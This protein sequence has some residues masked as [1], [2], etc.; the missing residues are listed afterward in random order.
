MSFVAVRE[1]ITARFKANVTGLPII[2]ANQ[3]PPPIAARWVQ[4]Q[5]EFLTTQQAGTGGPGARRWR[6]TGRVALN[7][8]ER[9][10]SGDGSMLTLM[11]TITGAFRGVTL[12][13]ANGLSFGAPTFLG[14]SVRDE[15]GS[16]WR[17]PAEIPFRADVV[18]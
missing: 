8:F 14:V 2:Q 11:D 7:L 18:G 9:A 12:D 4:M 15:A 3:S 6:I 10:D 13:V 16:H 1:A 17:M 5:V